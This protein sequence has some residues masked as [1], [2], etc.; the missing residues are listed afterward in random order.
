MSEGDRDVCTQCGQQHDVAIPCATPADGLI[1]KAVGDDY[2]IVQLL[3]HGGMGSV[4]LAYQCSLRRSVV[5][6]FMLPQFTEGAQGRFE[7]E[8]LAA[9]KLG[10]PHIVSV[11]AYGTWEG[12]PY[13]VM[14]HLKGQ[15]CGSLIAQHE[16]LAVDRAANI[17]YQA[18]LGLSAAHD[19]K[20]VHRDIKPE[21]LWISD[22]GDKSDFVKVLD[23]GIAKYREPGRTALTGSGA[24]MGTVFYMS[25]EQIQDASKVD[26]RTDI[27]ALGVV[28]YELLTGYK[29]FEG[30]T[31]LE[32]MNR[33]VSGSPEPLGNLRP[34]LPDALINVVNTALQSDP[35][36]RFPSVSAMAE[37]LEPFTA[38]KSLRPR[39]PASTKP[40][41]I[42]T[43]VR[44]RASTSQQLATS[45]PKIEERDSAAVGRK[46]WLFQ[47]S[48]GLI[49]LTAAG[50]AVKTWYGGTNRG[51]HAVGTPGATDIPDTTMPAPTTPNPQVTA[52][53]SALA[54]EP[55]AAGSGPPAPASVRTV[56]EHQIARPNRLSGTN[57]KSQGP[58]LVGATPSSSAA[59]TPA[60]PNAIPAPPPPRRGAVSIDTDNPYPTE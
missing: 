57:A 54:A 56:P 25:P 50:I 41:T 55:F 46:K 43:G 12:A 22:P 20:I 34:D 24:Q 2:R 45:L 36:Q 39:D 52:E 23:F 30:N 51:R 49:L 42:L 32:V 37:A 60:I 10:N 26:A 59:S 53:V 5:V 7:T 17:V 38:R 16:Q 18:C 33:I 1:G 9:G 58:K 21:N 40:S 47:V 14:E 13:L 11:F 44:V 31:S 48:I 6:K 27:W 28:L 8:A 4:Y 3:G 19:A 15:D 35:S 29:A